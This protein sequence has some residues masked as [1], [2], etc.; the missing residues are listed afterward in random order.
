MSDIKLSVVITSVILTVLFAFLYFQ[1]RNYEN[2]KSEMRQKWQDFT[3]TNLCVISEKN[4]DA[5]TISWKCA[6]GIIYTK[7]ASI[8]N[9]AK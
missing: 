2:K 4:E 3:V 7:P 8:L 5:G 1:E 9:G 6:D